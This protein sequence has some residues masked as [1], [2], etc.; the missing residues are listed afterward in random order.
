VAGFGLDVEAGGPSSMLRAG[1]VGAESAPSPPLRGVISAIYLDFL[2]CTAGVT[3]WPV[4][5]GV[6]RTPLIDILPVTPLVEPLLLN[7]YAPLK[8][9]LA[10]DLRALLNKMA[11]FCRLALATPNFFVVLASIFGGLSLSSLPILS[12]ILLSAI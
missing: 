5:A 1:P 2:T 7:I 3:N 11:V 9:I 8:G 12:K 10:P 4:L 6:L